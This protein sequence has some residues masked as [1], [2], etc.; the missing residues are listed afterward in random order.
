MGTLG[1]WLSD[2]L[3]VWVLRSYL[4]L[5]LQAQRLLEL[6]LQ[7]CFSSSSTSSSSKCLLASSLLDLHFASLPLFSFSVSVLLLPRFLPLFLVPRSSSSLSPSP[8]AAAAAAA[9]VSLKLS[10]PATEPSGDRLQAYSHPYTYLP[11]PRFSFAPHS[12]GE[13]RGSHPAR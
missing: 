11:P 1:G 3:T 10:C 9:A 2:C 13:R 12:G 5:F 6:E 8:A 7:W 4:F